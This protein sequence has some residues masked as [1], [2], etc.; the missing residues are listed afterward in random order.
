[1]RSQAA[2]A[3]ARLL[4]LFAGSVQKSVM[5]LLNRAAGS[6]AG[7][8]P[9]AGHGFGQRSRPSSTDMEAWS[10]AIPLSGDSA[11]GKVGPDSRGLRHAYPSISPYP[12]ILRNSLSTDQNAS[13]YITAPSKN[14]AP[15]NWTGALAEVK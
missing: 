1:M 13:A 8:P 12:G 6:A 3:S 15:G 4:P 7:G 9:N 5:K 14:G 11:G 2:T 10:F